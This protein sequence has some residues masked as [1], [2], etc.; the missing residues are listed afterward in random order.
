LANLTESVTNFTDGTFSNLT[1][2]LNMTELLHNATD[3]VNKTEFLANTT[4]KIEEL[5]PNMTEALI[6]MES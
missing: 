1:E 3:I 2:S 4:S 5:M 6:D